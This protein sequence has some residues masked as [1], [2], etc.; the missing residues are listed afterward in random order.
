MM[1]RRTERMRA[2]RVDTLDRMDTVTEAIAWLA[3]TVSSAFHEA[4]GTAA[5]GRH[6]L[7]ELGPTA[8]A[9]RCVFRIPSAAVACSTLAFV[10]ETR[11]R[12]RTLTRSILHVLAAL[13]HCPLG[14]I[15]PLTQFAEIT[16]KH[17]ND[18]LYAHRVQS[19]MCN[20]FT[21]STN[22]RIC[23]P[24]ITYSRRWHLTQVRPC[25]SPLNSCRICT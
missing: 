7:A 16:L 23:S 24:H 13:A 9:G 17:V 25:C 12:D 11:V 19:Q 18:H 3:E 6:T 15:A 22:D 21:H 4:F 20:N 5:A 10:A 14:P 2:V 1:K 8:P